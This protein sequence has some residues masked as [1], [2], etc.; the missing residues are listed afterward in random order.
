MVFKRTLCHLLK[1]K[2]EWHNIKPDPKRKVHFL[3]EHNRNLSD[4][5]IKS[6][7]RVANMISMDFVKHDYII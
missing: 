3:S 1:R 7:I 4:K 6:M 5:L 2:D